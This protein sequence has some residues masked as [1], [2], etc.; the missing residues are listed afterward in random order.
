MG[1]VAAVP[2][3][4][5]IKNP[6][7]AALRPARSRAAAVL[8]SEPVMMSLSVLALARLR[9][10]YRWTRNSAKV[11]RHCGGDADRAGIAKGKK[12]QGLLGE[13]LTSSRSRP[14]FFSGTGGWLVFCS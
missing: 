10:P 8:S 4:R 1:S 3:P 2:K 14:G 9:H 12:E 5:R 11:G 7:C 13:A 6:K